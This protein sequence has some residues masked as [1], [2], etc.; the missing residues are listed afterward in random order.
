[1]RKSTIISFS[2]T[3]LASVALLSQASAS[4]IGP[5]PVDGTTMWE[6]QPIPGYT[7]NPVAVS[8][9]PAPYGTLDMPTGTGAGKSAGWL[10]YVGYT[11]ERLSNAKLL[12]DTSLRIDTVHA[13]VYD[14]STG[15]AQNGFSLLLWD[16]AGKILDFGI[17]PA[18]PGSG[19]N[20]IRTWQ[21][22]GA[23]TWT[24]GYVWG[25]TKTGNNYYTY[26]ISQNPDGTLNW[27]FGWWENGVTIGS[28]SGTTTEAYGVLS[29]LWLNVSQI[30]GTPTHN[31]KWTEFSYTLVPEPSTG[32][33]LACGLGAL[34]AM[35][36]LRRR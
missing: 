7:G 33:T 10:P 28:T 2:V 21:Y 14:P 25:R 23:G 32:L 1:M 31:Y 36:R 13:V 11:G 20:N 29:D 16:N 26:D 19:V 17:R 3:F 22:D 15:T 27:T 35:F 5:W 18:L 6:N 24:D 34:A 4:V 8:A 12:F 9:L 30:Q